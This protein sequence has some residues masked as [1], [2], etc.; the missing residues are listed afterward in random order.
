MLISTVVSP[1]TSLAGK[2]SRLVVLDLASNNLVGSIAESIGNADR[3]AVI[4]LCDNQLT[5]TLPDGLYQLQFVRDLD[6]SLNQLEGP[7]LDGITELLTTL[8]TLDLS[9][10]AFTGEL[11]ALFGSNN[12]DYLHLE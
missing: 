10:N 12:L 6:L 2:L 8:T 11:P 9:N 5:G 1:V 3:L 7:L 4:N